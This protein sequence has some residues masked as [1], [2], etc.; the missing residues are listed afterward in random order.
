V[1]EGFRY[2]N[3][4]YPVKDSKVYIFHDGENR[5]EFLRSLIK[6]V[7]SRRKI[8]LLNCTEDQIKAVVEC[9]INFKRVSVIRKTGRNVRVPSDFFRFFQRN[10]AFKSTSLRKYLIKHSRALSEIVAVVIEFLFEEALNC[11][12]SV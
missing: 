9:L 6:M 3:F 2:R 10:K 8:T 4:L 1:Q 7:A 12:Y 5:S 11:L